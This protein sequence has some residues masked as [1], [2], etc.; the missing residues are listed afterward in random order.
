M[1][2]TVCRTSIR[3]LMRDTTT[4]F[5]SNALIDEILDLVLWDELAHDLAAAEPMFYRTRRVY[6]GQR[7]ALDGTTYEQYPLPEDLLTLLW[8]DRDD[9]ASRPKLWEPRAQQH[10]SFRFSAGHL[11]TVEGTVDGVATTFTVPRTFA[12]GGVTI[13]GDRFKILPAPGS[14]AEKYGVEYVRRPR[15]A[16]GDSEQVDVPPI[17]EQSVKLAT[18]VKVLMLDGDPHAENLSRMLYG[19]PRNK[20]DLGTLGRAKKAAADRQTGDLK[21]GTMR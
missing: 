19:D 1:T 17:F 18:A 11:G 6:T 5:H 3:T 21:L 20:D 14:T 16:T 15:K 4:D 2:K 12:F 13:F 7:D 9:L 8:I 10:D